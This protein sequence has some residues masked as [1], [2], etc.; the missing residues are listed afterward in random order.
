MTLAM[1]SL[2]HD[3][4]QK[5]SYHSPSC[6]RGKDTE[7]TGVGNGNFAK[8]GEHFL[9]IITFVC[10]VWEMTTYGSVY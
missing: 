5:V 3:G 6:V 8:G 1:L 9:Y 10:G 2:V 7:T 4:H